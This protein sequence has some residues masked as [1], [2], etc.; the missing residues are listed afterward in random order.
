V[1]AVFEARWATDCSDCGWRITVGKLAR[2]NDRGELVHAVCPENEPLRAV[3][4]VC[5]R[6]FMERAANGSC[7]CEDPNPHPRTSP[8]R[9]TDE[10]NDR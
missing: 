7:T 5:P 6:C 10:R 1:S 3:G 4:E 8:A 2:Y 9:G